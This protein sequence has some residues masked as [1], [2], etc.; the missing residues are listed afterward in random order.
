[1][2]ALRFL[3]ILVFFSFCC[4]R[5]ANAVSREATQCNNIK[6]NQC[7][8]LLGERYA[9]KII[10]SIPV[11]SKTVDITLSGSSI[12]S[13]LQSLLEYVGFGQFS[14][15]LDEATKM[16]RVVVLDPSALMALPAGAPQ[17]SKPKGPSTG[18]PVP[19]EAEFEAYRAKASKPVP[20][21][22]NAKVSIPGFPDDQAMTVRQIQQRQEAYTPGPNDLVLPPN[23]PGGKNITYKELKQMMLKANTP[24]D[25]DKPF[26][27][28]DGTQVIP[29][30]IKKADKEN[31]PTERVMPPSMKK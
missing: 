9:K 7:L 22:L 16:I 29:S 11:P 31:T 15:A 24:T 10:L 20:I 12:N 8:N 4:S 19:S 23:T 2:I 25:P 1:M 17:P 3:V 14:I 21:D 26:T 30:K 18:I 27:M 13:D 28:P 5:M 6:L